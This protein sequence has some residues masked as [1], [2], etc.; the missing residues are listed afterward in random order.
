MNP[1]THQ[2]YLEGKQWK[3]SSR[4]QKIEL[5]TQK[6]TLPEIFRITYERGVVADTGSSDWCLVWD[7]LVY[8]QDRPL[9]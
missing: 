1:F 4:P 2:V 5:N 9:V 7:T 6:L 8:D 3:D